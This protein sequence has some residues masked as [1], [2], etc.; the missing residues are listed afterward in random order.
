[1]RDCNVLF[2]EFQGEKGFAEAEKFTIIV[3]GGI[4]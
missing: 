1:M 2:G 4:S 3:V